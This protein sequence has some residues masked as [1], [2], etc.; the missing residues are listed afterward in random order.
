MGASVS[1]A[2]ALFGISFGALAVA[3]G[4]SVWQTVA[5][6]ALMFTGGS[7]FAFIG[8]LAS[9][10]AP[11]AATAGATL[12]SVRNSIYAVQLKALLNPTGV[13]KY[14]AAQVTIDESM[15]VSTAQQDPDEQHRGFWVT[16]IGVYLGW[17]LAT[18][19]G[20]VLGDF[21]AEPEAL[22][23]DGAVVAAFLGLLWPRLRGR[24]PWALAVVAA[25]VTVLTTPAV[26]AGI[27][28]LI[29]AAVAVVWSLASQKPKQS[30]NPEVS[31]S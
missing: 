5:L 19:I 9:G 15:A 13:K 8:V 1:A 10:G 14:V 7:Q 6:S 31:R 27:P 4:L 3:A 26:P 23:L 20:A 24:E 12:L 29:A 28:I 16:G 21:I 30:K 11:A 2:V 18:L 17:N 25:L 22:G